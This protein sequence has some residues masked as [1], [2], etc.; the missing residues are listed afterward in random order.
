M[1]GLHLHKNCIPL[2]LCSVL[3]G[4]RSAMADIIIRVYLK[5]SMGTQHIRFRIEGGTVSAQLVQQLSHPSDSPLSLHLL[6]PTSLTGDVLTTVEEGDDAL[7]TKKYHRLVTSLDSPRTLSTVQVAG[8]SV[9]A[10]N[11]KS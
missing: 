10:H 9:P 2:G 8:T 1:L 3:T 5:E 7:R 6:H 11:R 4:N